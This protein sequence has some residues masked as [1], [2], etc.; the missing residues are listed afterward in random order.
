[1][2]YFYLFVNRRNERDDRRSRAAA[3]LGGVP[4]QKRNNLYSGRKSTGMQSAA[5]ICENIAQSWFNNQE[6]NS[7]ASHYPRS[8][9][10]NQFNEFLEDDDDSLP[11]KVF[12]RVKKSRRNE[13]IKVETVNIDDDDNISKLTGVGADDIVEVTNA[14]EDN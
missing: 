1:M 12:K 11:P 6:M 14:E 9:N 8:R 3:V 2:P 10:Y 13:G 4:G 7:Y 5:E